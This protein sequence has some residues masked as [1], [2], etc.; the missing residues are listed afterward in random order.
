MAVINVTIKID[1]IH[2]NGLIA[3]ERI[4][5]LPCGVISF[6]LKS[7]DRKPPIDDP[8]MHAGIILKGSAAAKGITPSVIKHAPKM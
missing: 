2:I 4:K 6:T 1:V 3:I 5:I 7:A 8:I